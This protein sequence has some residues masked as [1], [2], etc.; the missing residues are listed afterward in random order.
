MKVSYRY[1]VLCMNCYTFSLLDEVFLQVE[2]TRTSLSGI[3]KY[4]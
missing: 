1:L 2:L 4:P 3:W